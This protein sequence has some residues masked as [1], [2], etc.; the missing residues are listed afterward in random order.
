MQQGKPVALLAL[1]EVLYDMGQ[2]EQAQGYYVSYRASMAQPSAGG[3]WVGIQ[4][5][6]ALD[7]ADDQAS[8]ELSLRHLYPNSPEARALE[9]GRINA[10]AV[11]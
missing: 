6:R 2:Y 1:A 10:G 11:Q 4:L 9:Q 5:A 7:L 3:L 8:L